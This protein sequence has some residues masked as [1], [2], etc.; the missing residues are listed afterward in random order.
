[1]RRDQAKDILEDAHTLWAKGDLEGVLAHYVDDCIYRSS[2]GGLEGVPLRVEGKAAYRAYLRPIMDANETVSSVID[3]SYSTGLAR[4]R[5]AIFIRHR[6]TGH[7][8]TT[9]YRQ[10]VTFRENQISSIDEYHDVARLS[11]FWRM[12]NQDSMAGT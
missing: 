4:A 2:T 3:F 12:A 11:T 9:T 5:I 7:K 6:E 8:I 1:M 10:I